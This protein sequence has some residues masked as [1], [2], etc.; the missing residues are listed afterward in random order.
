M[1]ASYFDMEATIA[2]VD[3]PSSLL[4]DN[5]TVKLADVDASGLTGGQFNYL[6]NDLN[7]WLLGK[8]VFVKDD[9]VYFNLGGSYN[10]ISINEMIQNDIKKLMEE[11]AFCYYGMNHWNCYSR[12]YY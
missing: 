6:M 10:S 8:D 1:Q 4:I 2:R 12:G 3:S 5:K 7:D 9:Y 11:P